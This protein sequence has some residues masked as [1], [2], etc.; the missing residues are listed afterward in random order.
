MLRKLAEEELRLLE[1]SGYSERAI[2][3][4]VDKVNMGV[5]RNPDIVETHTGPC[6][7]VIKL[8]LKVD[9]NGLIEDVKFHYLGCPG[10]AASTSAMTLLVKGKTIEEAKE[11]TEDD[12]LRE[13][14]DLPK[15]KTDCPKLALTTLRN[16]ITKYMKKKARRET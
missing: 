3:L 10:S 6:G 11:L 1:K 5:I 4:Y 12:I 7:D 14:E 9:K 8:Y 13:L 16:A 2:Q 15:P